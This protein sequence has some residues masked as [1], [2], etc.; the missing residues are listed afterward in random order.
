MP[1]LA[2]FSVYS[3]ILLPLSALAKVVH[4]MPQLT[5]EHCWVLI[6]LQGTGQSLLT[7]GQEVPWISAMA[8]EPLSRLWHMA[9][10]AEKQCRKSTSAIM[11]LMEG[12][13]GTER[14]MSTNRE[15]CI[16]NFFY[17]L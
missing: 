1:V 2:E 4:F 7:R 5:E 6:Q 14:S 8:L 11:L 17:G 12:G 13:S 10:S 15:S 16:I 9:A 3:R